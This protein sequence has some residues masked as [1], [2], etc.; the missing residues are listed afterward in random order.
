M[1]VVREQEVEGVVGAG[2]DWEKKRRS[3]FVGLNEALVVWLV[4]HA[5]TTTTLV[6][7][8]TY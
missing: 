6:E 7:S 3:P 5:V 8:A 1:T 4:T 2:V